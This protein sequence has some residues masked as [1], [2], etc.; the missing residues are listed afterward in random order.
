[1]IGKSMAIWRR[2]LAALGGFASVV[3]LLA[4]DWA[5]GRAVTKRLGKR[6]VIA[7]RPVR[8]VSCRQTVTQ[9]LARWQRWSVIHRKAVGIVTYLGE[10][11]L[12]P[13][14]LSLLAL[15]IA[16]SR[17][18]LEAVSLCIWLRCLSDSIARRLLGAGP[19]TLLAL[20]ASPGKDLLIG[21]AWLHGLC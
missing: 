9:F 12:N 4:E 10:L 17:R 20:I 8:N 6:I 18:T 14:L 21:V 1:V 3:D 5:I 19:T 15:A 13:V 11:L 16:P 7:R 2:D